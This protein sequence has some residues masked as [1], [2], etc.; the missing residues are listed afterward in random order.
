MKLQRY[1]AAIL[2]CLHVL[3]SPA[4]GQRKHYTI[5]NVH[6][7]NDYEHTKPFYTAYEAGVGSIEAD[8]FLRSG[9]LYV[10]HDS[11]G[12]GMERTLAKL[13][14]DPL[15]NTV[16]G[17][18]ANANTYQKLLLLIDFKTAAEPTLD[19]L[20]NLF[21]KYSELTQR[22]QLKIVITG[23]RPPSSKWSSYPAW[24]FFDGRP[25]ETYDETSLARVGLISESFRKYSQWNGKGDLVK[26]DRKKIKAIVKKAH[27]LNKPI[28]FW[29]SPDTPTAWRQLMKLKVDYINT[30]KIQEIA[31]FMQKQ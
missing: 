14:L 12:I 17:T 19:A 28:R 6:S 10:S 2:V 5:A 22:P 4:F 16:I 1:F 18:P 23:N 30:D 3:L 29:A 27:K 7:H 24:I 8:V 31:Q 20:I 25:G 13:Y 9:E 15:R 26:S 21:K 11:A